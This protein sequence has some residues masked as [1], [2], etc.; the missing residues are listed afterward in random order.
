MLPPEVVLHAHFVAIHV[1]LSLSALL[2]SLFPSQVLH[3]LQ[4]KVAARSPVCFPIA[5]I[6][7]MKSKVHLTWLVVA[8]LVEEGIHCL[9]MYRLCLAQPIIYFLWVQVC[10]GKVLLSDLS[11]VNSFFLWLLVLVLQQT[12]EFTRVVSKLLIVP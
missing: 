3:A 4:G 8:G 11:S 9:D 5:L 2:V 12:P 1:L 6:C 10:C 7:L